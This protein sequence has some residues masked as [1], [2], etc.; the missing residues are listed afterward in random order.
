MGL[1]INILNKGPNRYRRAADNQRE[2]K[3]YQEAAALG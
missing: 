1:P 3:H 2:K